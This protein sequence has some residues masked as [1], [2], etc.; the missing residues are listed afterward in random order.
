MPL[1]PAQTSLP[2]VAPSRPPRAASPIPR[3]AL[4]LEE[5]LAVLAK[6]LAMHRVLVL[7]C[8]LQEIHHPIRCARVD[9]I[10]QPL[11]VEDHIHRFGWHVQPGLVEPAAGD[12]GRAALR[13]HEREDTRIARLVRHDR[14]PFVHGSACL[15]D[16]KPLI[17]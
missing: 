10:A 2:H 8:P 3:A 7:G 15:K 4:L 6:L 14:Q 17:K 16:A 12:R 1:Q 13:A 5:K 9:S 11:S